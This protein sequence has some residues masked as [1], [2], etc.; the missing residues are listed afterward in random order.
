M[1]LTELAATTPTKTQKGP[2]CSVCITIADLPP[3]EAAALNDLLADPR[4]RYTTLADALAEQGYPLK[5][6]VLGRHAR[7]ECAAGIKL[8]GK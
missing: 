4:W 5:S 8:R 3:D 1:A 6:F 2:T 7:G